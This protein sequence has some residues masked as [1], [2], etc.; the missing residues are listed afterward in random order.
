MKKLFSILASVG[1]ILLD[2]LALFIVISVSSYIDDK[3]ILTIVSILILIY[4]FNLKRDR[5]N[6][7]EKY[8][9]KNQSLS[10]EAKIASGINVVIWIII[11]IAAVITLI[12]SLG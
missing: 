4:S 8:I 6:L 5:R 7:Q 10:L 2:V 12:G 3:N 9:E 11:D 1:S